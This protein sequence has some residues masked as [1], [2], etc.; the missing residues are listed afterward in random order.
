LGWGTS[1]TRLAGMARV[2]YTGAP[3][4]APNTVVPMDTGVLLR[5]DVPLDPRKAE[6]RDN[7]SL[8]SWQYKRTYQYGSPQ[9]KSDGSLGIDTLPPSHA[10]L[11]KDGRSVFLAVPGMKPSMQ[12]RLAWTLATSSGLAFQESAYFT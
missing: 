3:V 6:N 9:Y 10:Y 4:L 8:T 7:Y 1:A 11:A 12:M 2:R 5:F